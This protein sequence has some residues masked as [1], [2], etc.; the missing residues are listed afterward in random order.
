MAV[1]VR[2][3]V[4]SVIMPVRNAAAF[5]EAAIDSILMQTE[6][7]FE[8][9]I[10][11]DGSDD[12]TPA[13]LARHAA[14]D[15]RIRA[16]TRPRQG[17][18]AALNLLLAEARG[19]LVARMDGDDI[20]LPHR[21]ARQ[22]QALR[23]RP[24]LVLVGSAYAVIDRAGRELRRPPVAAD[25][26]DIAARLRDANCIAHPT[27]MMW[28]DAVRPAGGYRAAFR[29]AEDYDLWLRLAEQH[30]LGAVDEVLLHY[31]QHSG[32]VS[33]QD[34][35]QRILSELG[36]AAAA[37]ARRAGRGDPAAGLLADRNLLRRAGMDA[38]AI[39]A[40][41]IGRAM[42]AAHHAL[43]AGD[44]RAARAA[45]RLALAQ[46]GLPARTRL[47]ACLLL[48]RRPVVDRGEDVRGGFG[49]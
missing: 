19:A 15:P 41:V 23:D 22:V 1:P 16:I 13:L 14:R 10:V 44:R 17:L 31:R 46:R 21:L 37:R 29:H 35:E 24:D 12:A 45:L 4:V 42:G 49:P 30:A 18:V 32:Q 47:H 43:A 28:R 39:D 8:F 5:L 34:V 7:D 2:A 27:V 38:A 3:P 36:A 6:R 11:D 48:L 33:V 26:A 40:A 25:S 20:A 9:L